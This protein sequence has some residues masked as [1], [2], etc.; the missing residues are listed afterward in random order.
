MPVLRELDALL[1]GPGAAVRDM[2]KGIDKALRAAWPGL[3]IPTRHMHFLQAERITF[4]D[5]LYPRFRLTFKRRGV[6]TRLFALGRK[7]REAKRKKPEG[8]AD[9]RVNRRDPGRQTVQ[10]SPPIPHFPR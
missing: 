9:P 4:F 8:V 1:E 2:S 6:K 3:P 7:L 5:N 10:G